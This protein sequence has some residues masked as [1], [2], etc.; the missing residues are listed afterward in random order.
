MDD[1]L[2]SI[3]GFFEPTVLAAYREQPDKYTIKDV[4]KL[5]NDTWVITARIQY[6]NNDVAIPIA[7][8]VVWA[9]DTPIITIDDLTI[10]M[11]GKYSARVMVYGGFYSGTWFGD[12]YGGI[13][14]GQIVKTEGD[15]NGEK[16][17]QGAQGFPGLRRYGG[18]ELA[19]HLG[20]AGPGQSGHAELEK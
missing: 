9:G 3:L 17:G 13:L 16:E 7:V 10:P 4:Q 2:M 5:H 8:R 19:F 6:G 20:L 15:G 14:S 11:L 1:R 18:F 12:R